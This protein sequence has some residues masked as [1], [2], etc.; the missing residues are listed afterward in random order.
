M[1]W[2]SVMCVLYDDGDKRSI[3]RIAVVKFYKNIFFGGQ[4]PD[5]CLRCVRKPYL[6]DGQHGLHHTLPDRRVGQGDACD[7]G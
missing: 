2:W 5:V 4:Q 3:Y 7:K 1:L 6:H